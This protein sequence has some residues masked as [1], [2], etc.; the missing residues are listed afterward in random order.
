MGDTQDIHDQQSG[1]PNSFGV[2]LGD[3]IYDG[4]LRPSARL[5][6][7][8]S[9]EHRTERLNSLELIETTCGVYT[10]NTQA[11]PRVTFDHSRVKEDLPGTFMELSSRVHDHLSNPKHGFLFAADEVVLL[12][13]K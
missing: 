9:L 12:D 13:F 1:M 10:Y 5:A 2:D 7:R 8:Y 4:P 3:W 6:S 11:E